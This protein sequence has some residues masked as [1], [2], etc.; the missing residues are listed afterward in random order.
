MFLVEHISKEIKKLI[1]N[2]KHQN[3]YLY[4]T[5]NWFNNVWIIFIG[6]LDCILKCKGLLHYTSLFSPN[7]YEENHKTILK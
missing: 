2:K 7:Q 3:K 1:G 4:N 6:F 5:S